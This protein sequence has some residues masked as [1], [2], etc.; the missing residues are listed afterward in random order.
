MMLYSSLVRSEL[1]YASVVWNPLTTTDCNKFES[2]Q[3]KLL[4]Y[5]TTDFLKMIMHTIITVLWIT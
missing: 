3:K 4:L 1:E 2:I 5:V